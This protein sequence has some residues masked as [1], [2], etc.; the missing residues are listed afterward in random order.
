MKAP[1]KGN[2]ADFDWAKPFRMY[3]GEHGIPGFP[4]HPHRGFETITATL[5]GIVD[6]TDSTGGS[7]RY[8]QGDCQWMTAGS[9]IQHGE[10][11]PLVHQDKPNTLKLYQIW[12]NLPS[13]SKMVEP[14]YKMIW[15]EDLVVL[16][17]EGGAL[18]KIYAGSING[19]KPPTP[20]PHSWAADLAND[21]GVYVITLPP[22]SSFTLPPSTNEGKM[23]RSAYVVTDKGGVKV[24]GK[25]LPD[26]CTLTLNPTL[27]TT[28]ANSGGSEE[29]EVLVLQGAPIG[30]PVAQR[31]PFV[32][33]TQQEIAQ[34]FADF[35]ATEFGGWPW[36][37]PEPVFPR[38]T[39]RF[40]K[41]SKGG[42]IIT[43]SPPTPQKAKEDL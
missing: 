1:I 13:K 10:L 29:G 11:F 41:V 12:L 7:G 17:G 40:A 3:H 6:H 20:P 39:P 15:A 27:P 23:N 42:K 33:N 18:A 5:E 37:S 25:K 43:L 24:D 30:E 28:F 31:G 2:G 9:G 21:V 32:M 8:G 19:S 16:P 14:E 22:G 34:A 38:E 36:D 26:T 4:S 35:R